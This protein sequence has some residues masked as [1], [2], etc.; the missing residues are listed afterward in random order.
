MLNVSLRA[1]SRFLAHEG[2]KPE[3]YHLFLCCVF[4]GHLVLY[5]LSCVGVRPSH[6]SLE[7]KMVLHVR[8]SKSL[9]GR[10]PGPAA[11]RVE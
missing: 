11:S 7:L 9:A 5:H 1:S 3:Y 8:D 2:G 10:L 4:H 6:E